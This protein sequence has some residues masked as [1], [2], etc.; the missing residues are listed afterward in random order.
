MKK[1][2]LVEVIIVLWYLLIVFVQDCDPFVLLY[3]TENS[4]LTDYYDC[5][6]H[7]SEEASPV[8]YCRRLATG[9]RFVRDKKQEIGCSNKGLKMLFE[10]LR[11]KNTTPN[12]L[13]LRSVSIEDADRYAAYLVAIN[14]SDA[15]NDTLC[16]CTEPRTFGK[17]CEYLYEVESS[18]SDNLIEQFNSKID[19]WEGLMYASIYCYETVECNSGLMCLDWRDICDGKQQCMLGVDEDNCDLLE[20][21]ECEPDEYRCRNGM[22][23]PEEYFVD[24]ESF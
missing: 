23:V 17:Y 3:D 10:E 15:N 22:C 18:F 16:L 13:L 9:A 8:K 12:D 14:I 7:E 11:Q 2:T 6:Y 19:Y 1:S 21:N 5:V 4:L 24:G 20:F